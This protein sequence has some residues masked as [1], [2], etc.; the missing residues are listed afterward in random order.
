MHL[1]DDGRRLRRS[2]ARP[3]AELADLAP[4]IRL[5]VATRPASGIGIDVDAAPRTAAEGV[6]HFATGAGFVTTTA[7]RDRPNGSGIDEP[8]P[9]GEGEMVVITRRQATAPTLT[10]LAGLATAPPAP[11]WR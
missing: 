11:L 1:L 9:V 6:L 8:L 2:A 10:Y 3:L 7:Q 4:I 5:A